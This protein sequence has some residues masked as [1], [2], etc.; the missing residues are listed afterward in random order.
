MLARAAQELLY[1]TGTAVRRACF[2]IAADLRGGTKDVQQITTFLITVIAFCGKV[3]Y[4]TQHLFNILLFLM[5]LTNH[6]TV[7]R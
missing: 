2:A 5:R 7:S 4:I 1:L 6:H 3:Y